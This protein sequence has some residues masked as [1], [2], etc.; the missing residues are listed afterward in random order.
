MCASFQL[1]IVMPFLQPFSLY[2]AY[3]MQ[4]PWDRFF[5]EKMK[6][7]FVPG[8]TVIDIGGGLRIDATR[9]NRD[10]E[11]PA[12]LSEYLK[13]VDYK[14]LDKVADYHP[15][16]VGDIHALPFPDNSVDAIICIA[17]LEHVEE[18]GKA[19]SEVYR[20]L[21][22]GGKAFFY[23]PFLFYYHPLKNYYQDFFRFTSDG[24]RYLTRQFSKVELQNVRGALATVL[25]LFPWLSKR[26]AWVDR[27]DRWFHKQDSQQTSGYNVYCVK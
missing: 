3:H 5:D 27:L 14:I 24:W 25:N 21:K 1:A 7:I 4:T 12:W 19:V 16:I 10:S 18:P 20:V 2:N 26:T 15:D 11:A 23:A 13:K 6:E 9:N 22:P 8:A 17:V